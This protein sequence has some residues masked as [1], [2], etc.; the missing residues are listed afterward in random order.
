MIEI[1]EQRREEIAELCREYGVE[2]LEVFGSAAGDSFDP[3]RSD[4]DFV[5]R[6]DYSRGVHGAAKRY[7][8]LRNELSALLGK[9]VDLVCEG[10]VKNPSF[11]K[12]LERSR[13]PIYAAA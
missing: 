6:F 7:F 12:S 13:T 5:V 8:H 2:K 9:S 11:L 3:V 4:I 10:A 1:L